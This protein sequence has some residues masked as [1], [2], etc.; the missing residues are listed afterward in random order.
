MGRL[1]EGSRGNLP[2]KNIKRGGIH[3]TGKGAVIDSVARTYS[4]YWTQIHECLDKTESSNTGLGR[5]V[6]TA[7]A[8]E[9]ISATFREAHEEGSRV[10]FVGNGGSA[11]I[12]SHMAVDYTKNGRIRSLALNDAATLTCFGNDYG[13]DR[14]FAKQL[15]FQGAKDD[16]LVVISSSG[17]S[18]NIIGAADQAMSMGFRMVLT[19]T[20]MNP[21]NVL[22]QKGT[23]NLYV[24]CSDYGLVEC[25]H[26]ILLHSMIG[27]A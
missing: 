19:L 16:V 15:E 2:P 22:R 4:G 13:Y 18:L 21:N 1:A 9:E 14:V 3:Y 20:G 26:L 23:W 27:R 11:A 8:L 24:P 7:K 17:R 10:F 25:S 6:P 5:K 12:A